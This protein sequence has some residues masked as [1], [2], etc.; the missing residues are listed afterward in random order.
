M[1]HS[2]NS[3]NDRAVF[4]ARAGGTKGKTNSLDLNV[5]AATRS[6]VALLAATSM[7]LNV[8]GLIGTYWFVIEVACHVLLA[9]CDVHL[10]NFV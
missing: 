5:L 7:Y 4:C 6:N 2:D 1:T 9:T 3:T 8:K 10:A